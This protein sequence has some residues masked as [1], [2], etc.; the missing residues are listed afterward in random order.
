MRSRIKKAQFGDRIEQPEKV[1]RFE[2]IGDDGRLISISNVAI[3]LH[4]QDDG[5]TLKVFLG[6]RE[7]KP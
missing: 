3:E 6:S 1:S 2:V 7:A 5:K 4:Y